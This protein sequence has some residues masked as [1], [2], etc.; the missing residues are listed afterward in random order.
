MS[1]GLTIVGQGLAGTC[2][3]WWLWRRGVDF[4]IVDPGKGGASRVAAG[5][6]N[7]VTGKNFEPSWRIG[8]FLPEALDFYAGVERELGVKLWHP[9]PV[10]RLS[11]SEKEWGKISAKLEEERVRPWIGGAVDAPEGWCGAV[12]VIGGGRVDVGLL[13][14]R[15][16][17]FFMGKGCFEAGGGGM[18][19][20]CEGAAGL[21]T[22]NYG[23]H[24][25]AKGEILTVRAEGWDE[26]RIKV[27]GGGWLVPVGGGVFRAGATYE[28][29]ELDE[30][31]TAKGREFVERILR[32]LGG[33][34]FEVTD[35]RAGVR[36]I[37]RRSEP[38]I[39]RM[40]DGWMFNGLGSKGS[41]YAPEV[42]A[43]LV[44][45][46]LDNAGIEEDL[47]FRRFRDGG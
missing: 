32:R 16:R 45:S 7:P 39:G 14:E 13:V 44:G 30:M 34:D 43:R 6:V 38:L 28:W 17:E 29:N 47:D 24:R 20:L 36:P 46:I 41:V 4:R 3:A 33:D 22:G 42:A 2:V 40:R 8:E 26:G 23:E 15:S 9:M 12:E 11:G 18:E 37:L 25:S 19:I 10:L 35:H 21:M 31:P 27:G 5:L 1:E